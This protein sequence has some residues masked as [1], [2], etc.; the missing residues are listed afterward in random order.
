MADLLVVDDNED[1]A[2]LVQLLLEAEGH[3]VRV[4]HN[5]EAGLLELEASLPDAVLL[6]IEMPVLDGP[7]MAYRMFVLN[8]GRENIPI[9]LMSAVPDLSRIATRIGT[10]YSIA[11]PFEPEPLVA[12]VARALTEREIPRP[13]L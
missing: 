8:L 4:A 1:L 7:S 2:S 5:G 10:P 13:A 11:K 9:V 12:L 6:D 3:D